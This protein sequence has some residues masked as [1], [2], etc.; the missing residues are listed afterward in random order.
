M[1]R[2]VSE[3]GFPALYVT[4]NGAAFDVWG[5]NG[6]VEDRLRIAYLAVVPGDSETRPSHA[7]INSTS[8]PWR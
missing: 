5:A 3:Y 6:R 2:Q 1:L 7:A 8:Q 4:E